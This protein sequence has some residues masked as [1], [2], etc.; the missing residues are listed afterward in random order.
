VEATCPPYGPPL[1]SGLGLS[2]AKSIV[3][4]HGGKI[5]ATSELG[6]GTTFFIE[7]PVAKA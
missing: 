5:W 4:I 1:G 7:L 6:K 3:D 2:I